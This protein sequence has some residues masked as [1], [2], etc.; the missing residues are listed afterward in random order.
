[1]KKTKDLKNFYQLLFSTVPTTFP[2]TE[3]VH[4]SDIK[5]HSYSYNTDFTNSN[6]LV[7]KI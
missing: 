3:K 2:K 1:M 4:Y 6:C 7:K 5:G